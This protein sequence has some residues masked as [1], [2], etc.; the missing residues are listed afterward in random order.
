MDD[1]GII[2]EFLHIGV[3]I[4]TFYEK[5][6]QF[7][8]LEELGWITRSQQNILKKHM[9]KRRP[10]APP[11]DTYYA[12]IIKVMEDSL[13]ANPKFFRKIS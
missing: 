11:E 8:D 9:A 2:T 10:S 6:K 1:L 3:D 12:G 7:P 13:K 4:E 5:K